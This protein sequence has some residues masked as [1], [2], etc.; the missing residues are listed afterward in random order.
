MRRA[1]VGDRVVGLQRALRV[2]RGRLA[3][4]VALPDVEYAFAAL[5]GRHRQDRA[6]RE[7]NVMVDHPASHS[8]RF[9]VGDVQRGG[10]LSHGGSAGASQPIRRPL[11]GFDGSVASLGA[12]DYAVSAARHNRGCLVVVSVVRKPIEIVAA[13]PFVVA[14]PPSASPEECALEV[15]RAA[16][17]SLP[18][19]MSVVTMVCHGRVGPVL[20]REAARHLCDAIVIGAPS[21][22]WSR[23]TG[24]V[25]RYLRWRA[26]VDVVVVLRPNAGAP[27]VA[28]L[29]APDLVEFG[30]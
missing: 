3:E 22:L 28:P 6:A 15:L 30:L 25:A 14:A 2:H 11:I 1:D 23:L 8:R 29:P 10:S 9:A 18:T 24:G 17:E 13:W 7:L 21:G 19:D 26:G 12:L 5:S 4:Y 16:V 27:L 20:L